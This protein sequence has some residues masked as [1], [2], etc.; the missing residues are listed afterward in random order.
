[1]VRQKNSWVDSGSDSLPSGVIERKFEAAE[2]A[3]TV[4]FSY[5]D[6]SLVVETLHNSAGKQLLNAEIVEYQFAVVA[7]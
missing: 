5:G 7:E 4:G 1:M 3:E 2:S 6:F